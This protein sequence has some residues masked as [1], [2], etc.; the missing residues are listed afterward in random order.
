MSRAAS[1]LALLSC[2]SCAATLIGCSPELR[3]LTVPPPGAVAELDD[4]DETVALTRGIALGF[5]CIY[6]GRPCEGASATVDDPVIAS[7]FPAYV[8]LLSRQTEAGTAGTTPRA[9]F[10]L[11]GIQA[12]STTLKVSSDDGD[13]AFAVEIQGR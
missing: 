10:V 4:M 6:Q 9:A 2:A 5:E 12:G 8:D 7:V 3:A 13:E 1:L 11:V